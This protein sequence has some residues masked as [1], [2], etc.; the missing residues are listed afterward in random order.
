M[1]RSVK[2]RLAEQAADERARDAELLSSST[3]RTLTRGVEGLRMLP[4][5]KPKMAKKATGR[6]KD[7]MKATRSRRSE[8]KP[9]CTM[10][11]IMRAIMSGV[12]F[13]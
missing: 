11:A 8:R 3:T 4:K 1:H 13:R 12:P 9:V 7:R 5:T 10:V 6:T 2:R